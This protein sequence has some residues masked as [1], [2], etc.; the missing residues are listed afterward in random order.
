VWSASDSGSAAPKTYRK[1]G[2]AIEALQGV[3]L[4]IEEGISASWPP[5]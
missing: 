4:V 3:D 2:R 5:G 1:A